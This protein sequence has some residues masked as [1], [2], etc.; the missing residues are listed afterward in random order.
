MHIHCLLI[1]IKLQCLTLHPSAFSSLA[2]FFFGRTPLT[3]LSPKKTVE[4]FLG[5]AFF[6]VVL[7]FFLTGWLQNTEAGGVRY[8]ML[9]PVEHGLGL[10]TNICDPAEVGGR[11]FLSYPVSTWWFSGLIPGFLQN[12]PVSEMQ[13]HAMIMAVFASFIAPFGGFFA[14][15]FKRALKIKDF[16]DAIPGHG[17]FTDRM[18]CQLLMGSFSYVYATYLLKL[19]TGFRGGEA[20][21]MRLL[22]EIT[23][24][25]RAE[26]VLMLQQRLNSFVEAQRFNGS[27]PA[28]T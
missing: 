17:G 25:L 14:S 8:L 3:K 16:G 19:G 4:G 27:A 22:L 6:T 7:S 10:A 15:G 13:L 21:V 9:C 20:A 2:G 24:A 18:D 28:L 12:Y 26:D 1:N 23:T 5:G 11:I